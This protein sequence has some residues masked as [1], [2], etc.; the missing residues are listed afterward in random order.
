MHGV[1]PSGAGSRSRLGLWAPVAAY[2]LGI[3]VLSS[4]PSARIPGAISDKLV[5]AV[6]YGGLA[7]VTLRATAGGR[8]AGLG[9]VSMGVAWLIATLY[10]V[11]DE[12][13]Q[14]FVPGRSADAD[15]VVADAVGAAI[16][17]V[18]VGAFGIIR[19]S[20]QPAN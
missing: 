20:R 8:A 18:A 1:P 7:V 11:S 17:V 6:F 13:H 5:H 16:A 19:R 4:L 9:L 12:W 15:D 3:F 2:M 14:S 10:G